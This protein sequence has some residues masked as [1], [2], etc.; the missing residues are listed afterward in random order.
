MDM[1]DESVRW[2]CYGNS[3]VQATKICQ[4]KVEWMMMA[5]WMHEGVM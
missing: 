1:Y 2:K 4:G 5:R 3:R